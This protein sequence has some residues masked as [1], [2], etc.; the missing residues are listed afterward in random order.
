MEIRRK[1]FSVRA[2]NVHCVQQWNEV[3]ADTKR[4]LTVAGFKKT[5]AKLRQH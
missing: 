3:P 5:Y 2:V 4:L 1:F